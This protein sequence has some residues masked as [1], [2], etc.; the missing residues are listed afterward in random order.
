MIKKTLNS[1][2][3][4]LVTILLLVTSVLA[5]FSADI[6]LINTSATSYDMIGINQTANIDFMAAN[7][8]FDGVE[9]LDTRVTTGL[10]SVPH[11]LVDDRLMYA[12]PVPTT[13]SQTMQFLVIGLPPLG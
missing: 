13:S 10:A 6:V 3:L 4:A 1:L 7:D 12:R 11:M 9:G 2:T 5:A 8:F